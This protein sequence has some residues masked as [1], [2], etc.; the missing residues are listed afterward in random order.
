MALI[1]KKQRKKSNSHSPASL[2]TS[3]RCSIYLH[4]IDGKNLKHFG[5]Y[6][7]S[8]WFENCKG[9]AN[10]RKL[11]SLPPTKKLFWKNSSLC[12]AIFYDDVLMKWFP[13]LR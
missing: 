1:L 9:L 6:I 5:I 10:S 2:K 3:A 12:L 11:F 13:A 7:P 8:G 4:S